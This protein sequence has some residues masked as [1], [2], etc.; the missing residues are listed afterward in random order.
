MLKLFCFS[1]D[2]LHIWTHYR[3]GKGVC[4]DGARFSNFDVGWQWKGSKIRFSRLWACF[5]TDLHQ[6]W[7]KHADGITASYHVKKMSWH[8]NGATLLR[9]NVHFGGFLAPVAMFFDRFVSNLVQ[10][11]TQYSHIVWCDLSPHYV[12]TS[13]R[14]YVK[15]PFW[16][17]FGPCSYVFWPISF[18]FGGNMHT[19]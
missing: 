17:F 12:S 11:C 8:K 15:R 18:K 13:R 7:Y 2:H 19:I 16:W 1:T 9:H 4:R 3:Y 5:L 14:Y 6:T 10:T